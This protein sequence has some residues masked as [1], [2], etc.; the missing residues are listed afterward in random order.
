MKPLKLSL[1]IILVLVQFGCEMAS[2]ELDEKKS[3]DF[4]ISKI[5]SE[6][7]PADFHANLPSLTV[8]YQGTGITG[9]AHH[10]YNQ[11]G[12]SL[13]DVGFSSEKDTTGYSI[14]RYGND[15]KLQEKIEYNFRILDHPKQEFFYHYNDDGKL[16]QVT[17]DGVNFETYEY[18]AKG[19]VARIILGPLPRQEFYRFE[20][21]SLGR[22][23][24]QF[25]ATLAMPEFPLRDWY[26]QYN[27]TG[28]LTAKMLPITET[29]MGAMFEYRYDSE[30]RLSEEIE[31]YPEYGFTPWLSKKLYYG[32]IQ[33][34]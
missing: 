34:F 18:N 7:V 30:G 3:L 17:R 31:N 27:E 16:R 25:Y 10:Y 22:I 12:Q 1:L 32:K 29:E 19:Q 5:F 11:K 20:Y 15:G 26:Y 4:S 24:R 28:Q 13:F 2:P 33:G 6:A 9:F 23:S 21:D 8:H 14:Y